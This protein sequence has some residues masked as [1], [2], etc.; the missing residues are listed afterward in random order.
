[1]K[2]LFDEKKYN[3][4]QI[5]GLRG[6]KRIGRL[7]EFDNNIREGNFP[8]LCHYAKRDAVVISLEE[9]ARLKKLDE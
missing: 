9:Y 7:I 2:K 8:I 6:G 3:V 4:F 5:S 1:M